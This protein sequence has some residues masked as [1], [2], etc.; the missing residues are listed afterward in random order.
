MAAG[1]GGGCAV[2]LEE[3]EEGERCGVLPLCNHWFHPECIGNWLLKNPTCPVCRIK[4]ALVS[5][6]K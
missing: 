1:F 2:C 4:V 6:F 3:F 5:T